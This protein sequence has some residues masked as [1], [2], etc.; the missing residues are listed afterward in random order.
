M[1]KM[2]SLIKVSLNHDMN[3]FRISTKRQSKRSKVLF[4]LILTA[5]IMFAIGFYANTLIDMLKPMNQEL[6]CVAVF[7]LMVAFLTLIEGIYKSSSLLFNCKDDNLLLS[8]PIKKRSVL[9]IRIF[10]FYVFELLYNSLFL[11]PTLIVFAVNVEVSWTY[12]LL[13]FVA[14]IFL[15]IVPIVISCL[16]GFVITSLSSKFKG[17]N[18]LQT[19][20]TFVFILLVMYLSLTMSSSSAN[21][22]EKIANLSGY[23]TRFYY[24]VGCYINLITNFNIVDLLIYIVVHISLAVIIL[25]ILSIF[26]FKINSGFKKVITKHSNKKYIIKTH[27]RLVSFMKKEFNK[28]VSTPVFITNTSFGLILYIII[29]IV[30]VFNYDSIITTITSGEGAMSID[31]LKQLFPLVAVALVAFVS[32]TTS[33]TSSMISLEGKTFSLL[34]SLPVKSSSIVLYKVITAL[35]IMVPCILVGDIILFL[36]F[37]F[38]ILGILIILISSVLIPFVSEL[39]GILINLKYPKMDATNDTEVVKQSMSSFVSVMIGFGLITISFVLIFGLA[40]LGLNTYLIILIHTLLYLIIVYS[41][42]TL[43]KKKSDKLFNNI[44]I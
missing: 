33:I 8:L 30:A 5:Y 34:K 21:I 7:S 36:K 13:S 28:F 12:Y 18:I 9:F 24:P 27:S 37:E 23:I 16:L 41:L 22:G 19:I 1:K 35:V 31:A 11:L 42:W 39:I 43:L 40:S 32:L 29:C 3:L 14:L 20:F 25:Y 26:Y 6:A 38:N 17:K 44:T 4:P 15:P 2:L 10:K